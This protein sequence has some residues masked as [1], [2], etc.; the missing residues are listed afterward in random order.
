VLVATA[1]YAL[2]SVHG[3]MATQECRQLHA[4]VAHGT[5]P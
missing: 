1:T 2:S 4:T 5:T 3:F